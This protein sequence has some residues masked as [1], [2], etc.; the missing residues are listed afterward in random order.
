MAFVFIR[1]QKVAG[2]AINRA[3]TVRGKAWSMPFRGVPDFEQLQKKLRSEAIVVIY[4]KRSYVVFEQMAEE[5]RRKH[6]VASIIRNPYDRYISAWAHSRRLGWCPDSTTPIEMFAL[7]PQF[8][9]EAGYHCFR[10][11]IDSLYDPDGRLVPHH[12]MHYES[13]EDDFK[14]LCMLA[15]LR[16]APLARMNATPH[17]HWRAY[18]ERWGGLRKR[19][20]DACAADLQT[21][22]YTFE[23][24]QPT[25]TVPLEL[26]LKKARR[27]LTWTRT[28]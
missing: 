13:L 9:W 2:T 7:H 14:T 19:V 3:L 11:Q 6:T 1:N 10:P 5:L 20:E 15:G 28:I 25:G 8:F 4:G 24:D 18:Y 26:P 12:V 27:D 23:S 21:L 22:P 17:E 16:H